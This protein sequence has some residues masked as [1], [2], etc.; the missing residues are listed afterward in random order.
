LAYF[1]VSNTTPAE[2]LKV[3]VEHCI[4]K[5]SSVGF[6]TACVVCD[7]GATNQQMF[8]LFG[9]D[10]DKPYAVIND[11]TVNFMFDPPHL[12][13]CLR[14]NL[15]KHDLIVNSNVI[16]LKYIVD[17]YE[18]DSKQTVK[19]A[20]KLTEKHLTLPPFSAMRVRL[21]AH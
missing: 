17:F 14:N 1:F 10:R 15:M 19:L 6:T 3:L 20:P 12:L 18:R 4:I 8:R 13:K 7:Q 5:L 11:K 9:V 2:R 21:A 16:S